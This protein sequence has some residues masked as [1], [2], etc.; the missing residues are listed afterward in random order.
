MFRKQYEKVFGYNLLI[1][2]NV[3]KDENRNRVKRAE[4]R[5]FKTYRSK[6][7]T[8]L[9]VF[10]IVDLKSNKL[11]EFSVATEV[12]YADIFR[13]K[14]VFQDQTVIIVNASDLE[15]ITTVNPTA[16]QLNNF[17]THK[18]FGLDQRPRNPNK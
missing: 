5:L 10:A 16:Y 12:D 7:E 9:R 2:E 8:D 1:E 14:S 4:K 11:L 18:N 17:E 15:Y 6:V 13:Y 3:W